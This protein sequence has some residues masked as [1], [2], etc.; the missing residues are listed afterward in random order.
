VSQ[1]EDESEMDDN[2]AVARQVQFHHTDRGFDQAT[3]AGGCERA[4]GLCFTNGFF[5]MS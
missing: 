5:P 3:F 4:I 2:M 1:V